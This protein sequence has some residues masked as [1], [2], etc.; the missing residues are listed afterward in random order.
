V[1]D[2][3]SRIGYVARIPGDKVN[4]QVKHGLTTCNA[5]VHADIETVRP[6]TGFDGGPRLGE[7]PH[8]ADLFVRCR[9]KPSRDMPTSRQQQVARAHR[10]R[11]PESKDQGLLKGKAIAINL[12]EW[13][14]V[15]A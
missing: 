7:R 15:G 9:L 10:E 8:H 2:A 3:S 13:A 1:P 12:T 4:V 14:G 11:V 5:D 6:V